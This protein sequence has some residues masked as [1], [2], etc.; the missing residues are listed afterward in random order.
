MGPMKR[1]GFASDNQAGVHP[2]VLEAIAAANRAPFAQ[3]YGEDPV[4]AELLARLQ[5]MFAAT[6]FLV[7]T[8]TQANMV[9]LG[10]LVR[11]YQA[12]VCTEQCHLWV[13][14]CGAI[15]RFTGAKLIP[16][17]TSDGKLRP[18]Q[19]APLLAVRGTP[20]HSQPA[21]V[22]VAQTTERGTVYTPEELAELAGFCR[23]NG[24]KLHIDGARL[25]N[26]AA[27]LGTSLAE[28]CRGF[29]ALSLGFTKNGAQCAECVLLADPAA[30][31]EAP[32]HRKQAGGLAAKMRTLAAQFAAMLDGELWRANALHA[33]RMGARLAERLVPL[34]GVA[35][36]TPV[37]ANALFARMPRRAIDR[38]L[39]HWNFYIWNE[40]ADECRFMTSFAT[41][42][43]LV[44]EFAA[45]V[46]DS[47]RG[48]ESE[49]AA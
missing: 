36:P 34:P 9:A 40:A 3:S 37:E 1:F 25:A 13:D 8:G 7:Q 4:T 5:A 47:L 38:L 12:I 46:T 21:V 32:Y 15:E 43:G 44:D 31:R 33:N 2:A 11:P 30:A 29:H 10:S 35:M 41:P 48:T 49:G 20:H 22:S 6:P 26:A 23:E 18:A 19:V 39:V 17:P 27:A 45:A 24:L 14:E 16:V 28:S 42:P